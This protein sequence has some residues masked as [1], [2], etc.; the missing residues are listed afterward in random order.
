MDKKKDEEIQSIGQVF[1]TRIV[2][3][4]PAHEWQDLALTIIKDLNIPNFKRSSVF[5]ICKDRDKQFVLNCLNDTKE[6]C[7]TGDRW[8][9]FFKLATMK[10][11]EKEEETE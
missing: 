3:K 10:K 5:K 9:Y 2:K 11:K 4:A 7:K 8:K 6:L 1:S